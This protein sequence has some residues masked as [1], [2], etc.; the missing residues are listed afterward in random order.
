LLGYLS[1]RSGADP[2]EYKNW[3]PWQ[4]RSTASK[5]VIKG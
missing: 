2:E 5:L 4:V 3:T 1:R